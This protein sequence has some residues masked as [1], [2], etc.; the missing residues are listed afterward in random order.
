MLP[1]GIDR[2][3]AISVGG[4]EFGVGR[5]ANPK[6]VR[7]LKPLALYAE[8]EFSPVPGGAGK[9]IVIFEPPPKVVK[10][11]HQGR[12]QFGR[13]D[14]D[15]RRVPGQLRADKSVPEIVRVGKMKVRRHFVVKSIV[16]YVHAG[17]D[18]GRHATIL[19][20]DRKSICMYRAWN[21]SL[22]HY[23]GYFDLE[24]K[25]LQPLDNPFGTRLSPMS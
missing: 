19:Q 16:A 15:R 23:L 4:V 12:C 10:R 14:C 6:L 17:I 20:N 13:G 1:R 5:E 25:T 18:C 24:Q 9:D 8:A 22:M 11:P 3:E 21:G 7:G 2:L